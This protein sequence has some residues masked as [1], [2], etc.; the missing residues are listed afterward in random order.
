MISG[1]G[2]LPFTSRIGGVSTDVAAAEK[3]DDFP[4]MDDE[5]G[6]LSGEGEVHPEPLTSS[7][8]L[9]FRG[10]NISNGRSR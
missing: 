2:S 9:N 1:D 6:L 8:L 4:A 7:E 3:E 10:M 5:E